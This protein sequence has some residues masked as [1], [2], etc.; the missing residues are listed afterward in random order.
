MFEH[1]ISID[2]KGILIDNTTLIVGLKLIKLLHDTH[3]FTSEGFIYYWQDAYPEGVDPLFR[4]P[5]IGGH[6]IELVPSSKA[7]P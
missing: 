4:P 5:D 7:R 1:V 2:F 3:S 6:I